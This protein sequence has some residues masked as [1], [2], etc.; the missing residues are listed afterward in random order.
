MTG[1]RRQLAF[2]G[3]YFVFFA[4]MFILTFY[5]SF[6]P[7]MFAPSIIRHLKAGSPWLKDK[8]VK[9]GEISLYHLTGITFK[10]ITI[11]DAAHGDT[12]QPPIT[13]R[14]LTLSPKLTSLPRTL[15][16]ARAGRQPPIALSA[17]I[18]EIA[19]G[20]IKGSL[21][22]AADQFHFEAA[23][24]DPIQLAKLRIPSASLG[25]SRFAGALT[26]EI[27]LDFKNPKDFASGKGD[28]KLEIDK[29]GVKPLSFSGLT[30]LDDLAMDKATLVLKLGDGRVMVDTLKLQGK[31]LP[32]NLQGTIVLNSNQLLQSTAELKGSVLQGEAFKTKNPIAA[33]FIKDNPNYTFSG[34]LSTMIAPGM[35]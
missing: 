33:G 2:G 4:V 19:D 20:R 15:A 6:D 11:S 27:D 18:L 17:Y 3:G 13:I 12:S 24:K 21:T 10:D 25:K 34:P 32:L 31:D 16:A 28:I 35:F 8:E 23:I 22:S 1:W 9:I 26:G 30:I 29:P 14:R 5:L 7:G